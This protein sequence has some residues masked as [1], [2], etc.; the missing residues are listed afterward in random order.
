MMLAQRMRLPRRQR[1]LLEAR[2]REEREARECE[3]VAHASQ[4]ETYQVREACSVA[5]SGRAHKPVTG[6]SI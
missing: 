3:A 5:G 1:R 6:T 2:L 4:Q